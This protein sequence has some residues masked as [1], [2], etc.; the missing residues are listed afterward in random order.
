MLVHKKCPYSELFWSAFFPHFPAFGPNTE[1]YTLY[2]SVF[3][4][5]A[6]K[7]R[8][9]ADQNNYVFS[10]NAGKCVKNADQNNSEYGHFLHCVLS[11]WKV[12]SL[13][14]NKSDNKKLFTEAYLQLPQ[15]S[16]IWGSF[17]EIVSGLTVN[18]CCK[19][20]HYWC[21]QESLICIWVV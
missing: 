7:C 2:L 8:K 16:K 11:T 19:V 13:G 18:C 10:P 4:R 14:K 15:T 9:N 3:R 1:R 20:N 12:V 5:N 17:A 6:G 21:L